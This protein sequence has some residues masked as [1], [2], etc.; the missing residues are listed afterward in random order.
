VLTLDRRLARDFVTLLHKAGGP[1]RRVEGTP[2]LLR[3]DSAGLRLHASLPDVAL[4][5]S[6][7]GGGSAA[8]EVALAASDLARLA[9]PTAE[10]VT[11]EVTGPGHAVARW[12]ERGVAHM[13]DVTALDTGRV[14]PPPPLPA[15]FAPLP[16]AFARAFHEAGRTAARYNTRYALERVQLRGKAGQV[17]GTDAKQ[18]LV[19]G[20]F[21]FPFG[22]DLLVPPCRVFGLKLLH[23]PAGL[24]TGRTASHVAVRSG[25]W[26]VAL[27]IDAQGRFPD[28][29]SIVPRRG[30]PLAT[31]KLHPADA[32][33]FLAG[34]ARKLRG[35]GAA[36]QP[37]TLDLGPTSA[38]R[39]RADG[40]VVE[41]PLG[42]SE[43]AGE[44][45][46]LSLDLKHFLRALELRFT[47][48]EFWG[49]GKP[50]LARDGER[51]FVMMA[52]AEKLAL[53]QQQAA[54]DEAA[55]DSSAPETAALA[56][57]SEV[58]ILDRDADSPPAPA[59]RG[60]DIF[61]EAE[62]FRDAVAR[63]AGHAGRLLKWL[64]EAWGRPE[65]RSAVRGTLLALADRKEG[66]A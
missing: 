31:L 22:E 51:L 43:V 13:Q 26:T 32:E 47:R 6:R 37:V 48:F 27:K 53:P 11:V 44:A 34:L 28:V 35:A 50:V 61:A 20:G 7:S 18:L 57:A 10:A 65:V 23:G 4:V 24:A 41:V 14:P 5:Y 36:G 9:A 25:P 42:R 40:K 8:G 16:P 63:A 39:Y 12:T 64:R 38:L 62:G 60:F 56:P 46:R 17:V 52:Q 29:V 3:Q 1:P 59:E 49:E 45:A 58:R 33:A 15:N 21:R 54:E 66:G 2:V 30:E 55:K 19:E